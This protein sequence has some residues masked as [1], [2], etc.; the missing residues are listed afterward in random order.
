M[1]ALWLMVEAG[2]QPDTRARL[3][4]SL[5]AVLVAL[6]ATLISLASILTQ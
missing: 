3:A 2:H 1:V 5:A 6:L 4:V